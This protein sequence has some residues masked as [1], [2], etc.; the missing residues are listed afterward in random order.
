MREGKLCNTGLQTLK[1]LLA[2]PL[3]ERC[4]AVGVEDICE[5]FVNVEEED[6]NDPLMF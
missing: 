2:L 3:E 5:N 4:K 1:D 6:E